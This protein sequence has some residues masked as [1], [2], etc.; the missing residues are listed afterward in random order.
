MVATKPTANIFVW[1]IVNATGDVVHAY[2]G[3]GYATDGSLKIPANPSNPALGG[4]PTTI[5][6]ATQTRS[7]INPLG[8]K[9]I[10][11]G[12]YV[13]FVTLTGKWSDSTLYAQT[14]IPIIAIEVTSS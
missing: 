2:M 4:Q 1:Y 3:S 8:T 5:Y 9:N 12:T 7:Q 14:L 10:Y 6:F 11:E 13:V